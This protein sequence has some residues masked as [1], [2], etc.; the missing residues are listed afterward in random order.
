MSIR[1][2]T[3]G[4]LVAPVISVLTLV[5]PAAYSQ[6]AGTEAQ[7][8]VTEAA[9]TGRAEIELAQLALKSSQDEDVR[10]FAQQMVKDHTAAAARLKAIAAKENLTVPG[11]LDAEHQALKQKLSQLKG[12]EFDTAYGAE[13]AKGHEEAVALFESAT[14]NRSLPPDLQQYAATTLPTLRSHEEM[15]HTL[16][17]EEEDTASR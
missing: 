9:R 6:D 8:F 7:H 17:S 10:K 14:R 2:F 1:H 5:S 13:M 12:D 11:E 4:M 3:A 15:A 16:H